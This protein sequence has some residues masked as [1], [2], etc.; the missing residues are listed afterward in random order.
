MKICLIVNL[1]SLREDCSIQRRDKRKTDK[2]RRLLHSEKRKEKDGYKDRRLNYV[3][4]RGGGKTATFREKER[5]LLLSEKRKT[6]FFQRGRGKTATFREE[7]KILLLSER[8]R[9]RGTYYI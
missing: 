1:R 3:R 2:E 7:E 9:K 6:E 8:K 4:E 5:R